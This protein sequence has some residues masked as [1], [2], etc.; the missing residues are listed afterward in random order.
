MSNYK[1]ILKPV[2]LNRG[3]TLLEVLISVFIMAF[4]IM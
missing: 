4:G 3:S 2:Y 1:F